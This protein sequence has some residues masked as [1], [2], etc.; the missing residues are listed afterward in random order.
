MTEID[1]QETGKPSGSGKVGRV[2]WTVLLPSMLDWRST[3]SLLLLA[4]HCQSKG[5][6]GFLAGRARTDRA[7]NLAERHFRQL[8]KSPDDVLVMLDADHEHPPDVVERLV[9]HGPDKGVAAA[10]AFQREPFYSPCA[11]DRDQDGNLNAIWLNESDS[12]LRQVT[13][14]GTGAV[15]IRRWVFDKLDE[16]CTWPHFRHIYLEEGI[17]VSTGED[18]FFCLLCEKVGIPCYVDLDLE[19]PHIA[20]EAINRE[21]WAEATGADG[22]LPFSDGGDG[23]GASE[24]AR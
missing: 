1:L 19:I 23:K 11:Y 24:D 4:M 14:V 13:A 5:Y 6:N 22:K 7:R 21:T 18:I 2:Y 16:V 15:A 12:G 3:R 8:A 20:L 10:L 9:K 17:G